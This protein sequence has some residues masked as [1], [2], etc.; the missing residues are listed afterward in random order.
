MFYCFIYIQ[1]KWK[2]LK[3]ELHLYKLS[4]CTYNQILGLLQH[5]VSSC[6]HVCMDWEK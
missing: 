4:L 1:N 2:I 6:S 5:F 3:K